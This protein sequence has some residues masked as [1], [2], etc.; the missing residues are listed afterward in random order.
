MPGIT[1]IIAETVPGLAS[2]RLISLTN[3]AEIP[4][5]VPIAAMAGIT[6]IHVAINIAQSIIA[7]MIFAR[8]LVS[9]FFRDSYRSRGRFP[10]RKSRN[11]SV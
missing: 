3:K 11:F 9:I 1:H 7:A 6:A 5:L 10:L 4:S 2:D 8:S